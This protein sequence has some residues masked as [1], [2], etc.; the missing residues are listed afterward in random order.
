MSGG[1]PENGQLQLPLAARHRGARGEE[2][3]RHPPPLAAPR[4]LGEGLGDVQRAGRRMARREE[5]SA[6]AHFT[7]LTVMKPINVGLLG[8]GTVG[9]GTWE[10]LNRNA[11]E[12]QR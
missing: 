5:A 7:K 10:V 12:I 8:I 9:G 2:G 11:D 4:R 6:F 1:R 3:R